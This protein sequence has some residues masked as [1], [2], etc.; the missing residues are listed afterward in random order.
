MKAI[1]L[2]AGVGSR[3]RPFTDTMPKCLVPLKGLPLLQ[4]Q[5][6]CFA[7]CGINQVSIVTGYKKEQLEVFPVKTYYNEFFESSNMVYSLMKATEEF[8]DDLIICYGDIVF[9]PWVL[10]ALI[11]EQ[12][13]VAVVVDTGWFDLWKFRM[14]NPLA[15]AESMV[16]DPLGYIL[17]LGK[18][19]ESYDRIQG[20]YIG[21]FK[22]SKTILTRI[23]DF[24]HQLDKNAL[25]DGK[26]FQ[27]MYMTSFLQALID[28][29]I[30]K[31]KAVQVN[32]GW[33]EVDSASDLERYAALPPDNSLFDFSV[34]KEL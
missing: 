13:E 28:Q 8:T 9:Q 7:E 12:E 5:L 4:Y 14:E 32:H 27:N 23:C 29:S 19:T 20:Q 16:L 3:L 31:V 21:L 30:V 1:V 6:S 24:Y 34:W 2:A 15:D 25:Y 17:Q 33:L 11:D 18:K 10:R 26:D 22:L